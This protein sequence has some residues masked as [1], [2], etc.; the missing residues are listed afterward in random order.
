VKKIL[1]LAFVLLTMSLLSIT[2]F[3]GTATLSQHTISQGGIMTYWPQSSTDGY[4][5]VANT[6][7]TANITFSTNETYVYTGTYVVSTN[8]YSQKLQ[9]NG[10]KVI[11]DNFT[12]QS[13][14]TYRFYIANY[15]ASAITIQN[16]SNYSW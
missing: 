12:I 10:T 14:G 2:A 1:A 4:T 9:A 15:A 7:V 11:S 5:V 13:A 6:V 16:G 8:T 3:A